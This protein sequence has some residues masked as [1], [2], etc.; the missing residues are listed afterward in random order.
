MIKSTVT[1][2]A[3]A[4]DTWTLD[5]YKHNESLY[6]GH[7]Q[8]LWIS[9]SSLP[10]CGILRNAAELQN[11]WPAEEFSWIYTSVKMVTYDFSWDAHSHSINIAEH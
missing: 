2:T 11:R 10:Q 1:E 4:A 5:N 6:A 3:L 9:T 7:M 8:D